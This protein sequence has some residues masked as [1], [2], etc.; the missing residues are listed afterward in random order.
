[1]FHDRRYSATLVVM[2]DKWQIEVIKHFDAFSDDSQ[3]PLSKADPTL[4]SF[5]NNIM[6]DQLFSQ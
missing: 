2:V 5:H 3:P 1:M 6:S 4:I